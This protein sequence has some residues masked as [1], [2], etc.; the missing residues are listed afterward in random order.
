[1]AKHRPF[2]RQVT[3][4]KR[5]VALPV[6]GVAALCGAATTVALLDLTNAPDAVAVP[7]PFPATIEPIPPTTSSDTLLLPYFETDLNAPPPV[8]APPPTQGP[9]PNGIPFLPPLPTISI[10]TLFPFPPG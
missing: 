7:G 5:A 1:M 9:P 3:M 6:L 10:P 8:E 4:P 2:Q